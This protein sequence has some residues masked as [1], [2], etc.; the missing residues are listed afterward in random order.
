MD[1][2]LYASISPFHYSSFDSDESEEQDLI[3]ARIANHPLYPALLSS[4][5]DCTKVGAPPEMASLLDQISKQDHP[6][7]IATQIGT[8]PELDYFMRSYCDALRKYKEELS[9]PIDEARSFLSSIG[10]QLTHLCKQTL[11]SSTT[12]HHSTDEEMRC[13]EEVG[14]ELKEMVMRKYSGYV[15]SLRKEMAKKRK[16]G[17]LPKDAISALFQWWNTHY[18]WPYPTEDDKKR[19][20]ETTGL[21]HKQIN[22]WFINQRKRH[23]RPSHDMSFALIQGVAPHAHAHASFND[24]IL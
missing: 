21:D 9:K 15:S 14:V 23:W 3:K 20:S 22:N 2:H 7:F 6:I 24:A 16:K 10:S 12:S 17:K 13:G 1:E 18:R 11:P 4:Y 5:I 8:D 19:L